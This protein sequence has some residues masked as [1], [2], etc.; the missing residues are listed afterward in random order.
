MD[1]EFRLWGKRISI[2]NKTILIYRQ[3]VW[4]EIDI[5]WFYPTKQKYLK[6]MKFYCHTKSVFK[7]ANISIQ[8]I[9]FQFATQNKQLSF[10]PGILRNWKWYPDFPP[11]LK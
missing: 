1:R 4:P 9:K 10:F 5:V 11:S 2:K 7:T 6:E 8:R 3:N